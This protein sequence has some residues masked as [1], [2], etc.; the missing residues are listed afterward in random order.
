MS[1]YHQVTLV[2]SEDHII[3]LMDKL[4]AHE[5]GLL[6]RA[7]S[8][9]IFRDHQGRKQVLLQQRQHD[10]YHCGG[11]W[12]NTCCSHPLVDEPVVTGGERRLREEMGIDL[13]LQPIGR[14]QY[15]ASF[16][17][18]LVEHEFDHVLVAH[19]NVTPNPN[20]DEVAAW[21][22][23]NVDQLLNE[24]KKQPH[25]YTPWLEPALHI[26]L[27]Y[28]K[29]LR[30]VRSFVL[31]EGRL[32]KSQEY[33]LEHYWTDYGLEC[34]TGQLNLANV[35]GNAHPVIVEI[36]FGMGA[37]L[38]QMAEQNPQINYIGI[39]VHRPGVGKLLH[40]ARQKQLQNLRVFCADAI[41]VLRQ[42]IDNKTL[43]GVQLFFP[44]PWPKK[45][46]HKRRIVQPDF[47][48]LIHQKLK[49][50]GFFHLATDWQ[51]YAEEMLT[52]LSAAPGFINTYQDYAPKPA[53]RPLTKFEQRGQRLGHGVWDLI[54][55]TTPTNE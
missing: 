9:F 26:A 49:K 24:I 7:F 52:Q 3:G 22:W 53:S 45:K 6:H 28:Q 35:F 27:N 16:D 20:A 13:S 38:L 23:V 33:A 4:E 48:T 50:G 37:S 43:C 17:N 44:D 1:D 19:A 8:V 51:A 32:T 5:K 31:R 41:D 14:F 21:R 46:H 10:K 2:D 34:S 54:F 25:Q 11:L 18:G 29:P 42:C 36:G 40:G 47:L 55:T 12:A 30:Q 15:R 39:E